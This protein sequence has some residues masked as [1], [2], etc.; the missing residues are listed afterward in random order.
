ML[1]VTY[2]WLCINITVKNHLPVTV[3]RFEYSAGPSLASS[4]EK[5]LPFI[6]L[7]STLHKRILSTCSVFD[8][9]STG[10]KLHSSRCRAA[11]LLSDKVA[12]LCC[13]SKL[14]SLCD[15]HRWMFMLSMSL[16]THCA[17]LC[18]I[19]HVLSCHLLVLCLWWVVRVVVIY[20][21][22]ITARYWM[23][24]VVSYHGMLIVCSDRV[25]LPWCRLHVSTDRWL[26]C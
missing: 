26:A 21:A 22:V 13:L 18:L 15:S 3:Q 6:S 19:S 10:Q 24:Q 1:Y 23:V 11:T 14:L 25:G 5:T 17:R 12:R 16:F 2:V 9:C 8:W 20:C 7:E 4:S